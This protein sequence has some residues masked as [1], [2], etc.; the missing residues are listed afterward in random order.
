MTGSRNR[1]KRCA[2]L[3]RF[4][5]K[6]EVDI[7]LTGSIKSMAVVAA[8]LFMAAGKSQNLVSPWVLRG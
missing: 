8:A 2:I 1:S 3:C 6:E 7:R 4:L 5:E